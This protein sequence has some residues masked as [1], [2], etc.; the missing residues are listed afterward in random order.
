M[1]LK[2][3]FT[4]Q[5]LAERPEA[6]L[7]IKE[8]VREECEALGDVTNVVLYD[9]RHCFQCFYVPLS[10]TLG[11]P[12]TI[13]QEEPEGI[14]SVRFKEEAPAA[15]CLRLMNGRHFAGMKIEAFYPDSRVKYRK[16]KK[17]GDVLQD[18]EAEKERLEKYSQWIEQ[19]GGSEQAQSQS[20]KQSSAES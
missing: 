18:E 2:H 3:M 14:M 16:S 19:Q 8:D 17:G 1:I 12:S 6:L 7:E 15:A 4:L 20:E 11:L 13:V 9:V 5:E 10:E